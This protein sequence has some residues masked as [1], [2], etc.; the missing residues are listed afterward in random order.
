MRFVLPALLLVPSLTFGQVTEAP[1]GKLPDGREVKLYTLKNAKGMTAKIM[2]YGAILTELHVPDKNGKT[3]DVVLGFDNLEGYLKGSPYF[4][5]NVGRCA[6]RIANGKFTLDGKEYT[7]AT[8][9]GKHSLHGGKEGFDK[10]LW[11]A[12]IDYES[13]P[14][15]TFTYVSPDGEEGYPGKLTVTVKY[16]L[17]DKTL[18]IITNATTDA[19]TV[20]NIAHHSYFNLAGHN[21]GDILNHELKLNAKTY[22]PGDETLIRTG[23][24]EPVTGTLYDFTAST[25]I[26]KRIKEIKADPVGYDV[27]YVIDRE[28]NGPMAPVNAAVV[29]DPVSGR[30]LTV[31]TTEPGI[32]FYSG[33]FLDGKNVGKGGTVYKQYGA[34][35]LEP[36]KYP[37][38]INKEGVKD[39]PSVILKPGSTY[40][41]TTTYAFSIRK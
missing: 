7:L 41:Q 38:A 3:A 1:F 26:G 32:Q 37:D 4:G 18:Q 2:T 39:W 27:N 5:A 21:S 12:K 11:T 17:A 24:I 28:K 15:V 19:T 30:V 6:N 34:F 25:A 36:Q 14:V 29:S 40:Y 10:K 20:C 9:N 23:K 31:A 33:N 35:C 8:N 16:T 13:P 22:T